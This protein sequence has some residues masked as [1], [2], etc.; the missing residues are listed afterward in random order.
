[1][2]KQSE[3]FE[4]LLK[5]YIQSDYDD[6]NVAYEILNLFLRGLSKQHLK[7]MFKQE[8]KLGEL[9]VFVASELG[10]T[11]T[12]L[13]A[14]LVKYLSHSKS[15]VRFDAIDALMTKFTIRTSPQFVIR[16]LEKLCD[17]N[18]YVRKRAMDYLCVVPN[19][20]IRQTYTYLLNKS[21]EDTAQK[22]LD[23][24]RLVVEHSK[25]MGS[26]KLW[27]Q[28]VSSNV[29]LSKYAAACMVRHY[30]NTVFEFEEYDLGLLNSDLQLFIQKIYKELSVYPLDLPI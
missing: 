14:Y 19:E 26:H 22:H 11:A 1:M 16:V 30:G 28:C 6:D 23:G 20:I 17:D 24:L 12:E 18:E 5:K 15:R 3:H 4:L 13:D 7:D 27:E 9:A 21:S 8:G 25:E 10:S 29:L 2:N